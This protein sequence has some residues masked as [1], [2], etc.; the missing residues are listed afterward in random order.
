MQRVKPGRQQREVAAELVDDEAGH[1]RPVVGLEQG[2][3][4]DERRE[5]AT[6]VDVAHEEDGGIGEPR[7]AH[8]DDVPG[9]E[10]DLGRAT[11]PFDDD[12]VVGPAQSSEALGD[13]AEQLVAMCAVLLERETPERHAAHHDL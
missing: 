5:D 7:D 11:R 9:R 2:E 12:Q 3:R 6:A 10:I 8:V 13:D 4:A 1:P